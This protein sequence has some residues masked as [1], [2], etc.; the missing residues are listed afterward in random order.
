M[1]GL[2]CE[3]LGVII[4]AG[5]GMIGVAGWGIVLIKGRAGNR[6]GQPVFRIPGTGFAISGQHVAVSVIGV[7]GRPD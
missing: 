3:G 7:T 2:R 1:A 6:L 4:A 5:H